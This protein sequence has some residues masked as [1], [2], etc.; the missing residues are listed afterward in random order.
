MAETFGRGAM[1]NHWNDIANSDAILAIGSNPAENHPA[2]FGHI[3]DAKN[4]G[5]KLIS[6]D[7][8]FTRT[9]AKAD[10]YAQMRS[11]TDI[12]FI[13]GMIKYVLNDIENNPNNYNMTYITEY[14]NAAY[15]INPE[16]QGP[17]EL[18]GLFS[19]YAGSVNETDGAKRKYDKSSWQYQIDSN[20]IPEK[21]KTLS[22][23]NCAFQLVKEHFARYTPEMV[24]SICGTPVDT[25][26]EVCQTYAA[27]GATGKAGT[28]LYAMGT[29]QHTVGAQNIR[30]YCILQLLLGNIGIAGGGINALRGESNVQ[31]ST[32]HCLLFHILPGYLKVFQD[33]DTSLEKYLER[34]T[35]TSNDP[36]SANWWQNTP[37]YVVSLL[38]AWYGD[39][40]TA[41]N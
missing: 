35:P 36:N 30:S 25:F 39:A 11:G 8:R 37:K 3:T 5:A 19:G 14:T 15:L 24:N 23:P 33:K 10:I 4:K 38:K 22:D 17:A 9:S 40:A 20:G 28:I 34:V 32:D 7:P 26:N 31:G 13:G 27:S 12:A 1:T 6:V 18:E 21:D 2:S 16:F 29:T 41:D